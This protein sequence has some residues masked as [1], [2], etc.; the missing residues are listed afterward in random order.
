VDCGLQGRPVPAVITIWRVPVNQAYAKRAR[1][2]IYAV[3]RVTSPE[4]WVFARALVKEPH[5]TVK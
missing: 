4:Q 2:H 1:F 3:I 5:G